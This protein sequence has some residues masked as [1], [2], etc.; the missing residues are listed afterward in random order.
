MATITI[1]YTAPVAPQNGRVAEIFSSFMPTNAAADLPAF[2]GTY[3]DTNVK[4]WVPAQSLEEYMEGQIAHPGVVA[5]LRAAIA[6]GTYT[7]ENPTANEVL[8]WGELKPALVTEGFT[9][10]IDDGG[11][12]SSEG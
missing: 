10:T 5:A 2:E 3:Y 6:N 7:I 4:G 12:T 9:V 11:D 1:A 8:Y